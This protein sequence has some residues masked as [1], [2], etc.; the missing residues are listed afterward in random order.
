LRELCGQNSADAVSKA[1][2]PPRDSDVAAQQIELLSIAQGFLPA[3]VLF[4]LRRLEI[5]ERIGETDVSADLLAKDVGTDPENLKRLLNA[6]VMLG[7]LEKT[8][9]D[10]Y[11]IPHR[12]R[13][14]LLNPGSPGYLG[15]WLAF[16]ESWYVPF[17]T[18]DRAVVEG[19]RT[20]MYALEP[21]QI[22]QHTLAMHDF[23]SFRGKEL[24]DSI[25]TSGART[26]LDVGCGPGTY[27]FE[28]GSRNP[29][30]ELFLLDLPAVLEVTRE[31]AARYDLSNK[32]RFVPRDLASEPIEGSYDLVLASNVLHVFDEDKIRALMAKLYA[33]TSPGGSVIVQAQ[34]L[35]EDH[36]GPRWPIFLDLGCLCF[37]AGGR[38]HSMAET[39]RWMEEA[40]FVDIEEHRM[41]VLNTNSFMRGH[42]R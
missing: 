37:T 16:M 41:S 7:V 20:N 38:N 19:G 25:N 15:H 14:M 18:L 36:A 17:A 34:F 22:R 27:A 21:D 30:I 5:F 13:R 42:K 29:D 24:P 39:R 31:I 4:A 32:I 11:S 26:L 40:G 8:G 23:A 35:A 28:I 3:S 2:S 12:Y 10:R 33:A 1:N 9:A 6:G